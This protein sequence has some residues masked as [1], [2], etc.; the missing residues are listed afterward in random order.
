MQSRRHYHTSTSCLLLFAFVVCVLLL[1]VS[2]L[3]SLIFCCIRLFVD[4]PP[5]QAAF[6]VMSIWQMTASIM[7]PD[8]H[9]L[10]CQLA[11]YRS[12]FPS[13]SIPHARNSRIAYLNILGGK[14][15]D[16]TSSLPPSFTTLPLTNS[17]L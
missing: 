2:F 14:T 10:F 3:H 7:K 12:D 11:Q 15:Q 4:P 8:R 9:L 6:M 16:F 13:N 17:P 5:P 1:I